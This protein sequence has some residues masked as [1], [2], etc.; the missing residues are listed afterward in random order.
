MIY[1]A[2]GNR[3]ALDPCSLKLSI[4][5]EAIKSKLL[6]MGFRFLQ[7][8]VVDLARIQIGAARYK[9]GARPD[10]APQFVDCTSFTKWVYGQCGIWLPRYSVQQRRCGE[11]VNLS[12][13]SAGDIV[14]AIGRFNYYDINPS[15]GV[16]HAGLATGNGTVIH[17]ANSRVGVIESTL[18]NFLRSSDNFRGAARLIPKNHEVWCLEVPPEVWV[19]TSDDI[20]W[21]ILQRI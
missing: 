2:V 13:I 14:F 20:R 8:N 4:S 5:L 9:R 17:A 1:R 7:I 6:A 11:L 3:C 12:D 18:A 21:L 15:E 10:L 16:G 19:E